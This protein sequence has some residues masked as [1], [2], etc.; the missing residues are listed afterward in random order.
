M[1]M[2]LFLGKAMVVAWMGYTTWLVLAIID[3]VVVR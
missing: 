2:A 1:K 3:D